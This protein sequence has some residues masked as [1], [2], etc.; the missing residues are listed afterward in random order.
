MDDKQNEENEPSQ[1]ANEY[2]GYDELGWS[3]EDDLDPELMELA[4]R[5]SRGS[6]LRPILMVAVIVFG[7]SILTDWKAELAYFFS[8]SE[9]IEIGSVTEFAVQSSRDPN[10]RPP[11][12]D[13]RYVSISGVPTRRS[14][15]RK[16]HYFR[17]IGG[18]IYVEVP[19]DD[20]I[21]NPIERELAGQQR[22]DVDRTYF[23]G[24]GR[25]IAFSSVSD[26]Y[27]GLRQ[28]Y[29][30]RYNTRFCDDFTETAIAEIARR[31]RE[32]IR[33]NLALEY[34]SASE[35]T[36]KELDLKAVASEEDIQ[37]IFD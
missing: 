3:E 22:G 25:L 24:E 33:Q 11:L 27:G 26:R 10:W 4:E 15:G 1:T 32:T 36:R 8:S 35:E 6:I 23:E 7:A 20:Y 37:Q 5:R 28:Y 13:N 17:L 18:E 2:D 21:S 16:H 31:R 9:P 30:E 19:R 12:E 14:A 34:E 29:N